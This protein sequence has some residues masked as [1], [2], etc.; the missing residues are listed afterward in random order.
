MARESQ[1]A[2]RIKTKKN[3]DFTESRNNPEK[4]IGRKS[5]IFRGK[6]QNLVTEV[7]AQGKEGKG[8]KLV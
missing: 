5:P 1:R 2:E 8:K 3:R 7:A 6:K 4:Q